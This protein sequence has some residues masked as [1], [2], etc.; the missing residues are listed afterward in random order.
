M[1]RL[2]SVDE[3]PFEHPVP[4][5]HTYVISPQKW[6]ARWHEGRPFWAELDQY[7]SR[8]VHRPG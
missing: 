7:G 6:G 5:E 4:P 1:A 8:L 3:E 2:A